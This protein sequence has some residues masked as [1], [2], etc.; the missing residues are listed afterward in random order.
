[1]N[2]DLLIDNFARLGKLMLA[3]G[4]DKVWLGYE[5]GITETEY[6]QMQSLIN[7]QF[8]FNGWFTPASVKQVL[9]AWGDLLTVQKLERWTQNYTYSLI[10]KRIGIIMAG[11]IPLVGFHDFLAVLLSGNKAVI[12]LSSDDKTLLPALVEVLFQWNPALK[13]RIEICNTKLSP[14]DAVIATGSNNSLSYFESYFGKYPHIFRKNRTSLAVLTGTESKE[15]LTALGADMFTYFGLGCRNVS[16]V[17]IPRDF[18]LD[19]IF[20]AIVPYGDIINHHKYANNYDYNRTILLMNL[21]KM[22]DN[23]FVLFRESDQLFSPLAMVFY[24]RYDNKDEVESFL[25]N[26]KQDIQ[27]VVGQDYLAFGKAQCPNLDDY[28]DGVDTMKWLSEEL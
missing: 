17:L 8:H 22:L 9:C 18:D 25:R 1:M 21:E 13:E 16:Q 26:H 6:L 11:N 19:R 23:G 12:K 15:D 28:A 10:P 5:S 27:A 24:H 3:L 20:E 14:I 7:K 4:E 2:R